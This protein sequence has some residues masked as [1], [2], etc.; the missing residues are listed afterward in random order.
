MNSSVKSDST[1]IAPCGMN[2]GSCIAFLRDKNRCYGCRINSSDK[3]SRVQCIIK[4]CKS[5][6]ETTT[7][8]CYDCGKFPCARMKQLDKR[9]RTKYKTG[10]IENLLMIKENG[11]ESF[12]QFETKRR[13]CTNCG[14]ALSVHRF[15]CLKCGSEDGRLSAD[16]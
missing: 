2:C 6:A 16:N 5:L 13:T 15:A 4:N 14:A 3:I 8:F 12:L 11:M 1:M 9:Y 7:K 10:L